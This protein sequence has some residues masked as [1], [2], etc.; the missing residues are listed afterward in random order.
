MFNDADLIGIP[1]RLT[2][3]QRRLTEGQVELKLREEKKTTA[4]EID[5]SPEAVVGMINER[6]SR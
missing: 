3:G 1:L 6:I 2:V 5:K 4:V